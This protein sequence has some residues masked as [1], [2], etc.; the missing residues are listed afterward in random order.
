MSDS[1]RP[2]IGRYLSK[3]DLKGRKI[4]TP[5]LESIKA[6]R[7]AKPK[8]RGRHWLSAFIN[9]LRFEGRREYSKRA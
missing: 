7:E 8:R 4:E 5:I 9:R 1:H 2:Y 3:A 6:G